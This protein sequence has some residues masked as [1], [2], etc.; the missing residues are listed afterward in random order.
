[1][2]LEQ[3]GVNSYTVELARNIDGQV[4]T[5]YAI[6]VVTPVFEHRKNMR[7]EM[8]AGRYR[9]MFDLHAFS[10]LELEFDKDLLTPF[11]R[12]M[13]GYASEKE[14]KR[15]LIELGLS[16]ELRAEAFALLQ[17]NG[18]IK[19]ST[20]PLHLEEYIT[21]DGL[22]KVTLEVSTYK[23]LRVFCEE[24]D[25]DG[26]KWRFEYERKFAFSP[27]ELR[28]STIVTRGK[29]CLRKLMCS[30]MDLEPELQFVGM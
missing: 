28:G 2:A 17:D 9:V 6:L 16:S 18:L 15:T 30:I 8:L 3:L 19:A 1:M 27:E 12:M 4:F 5:Q 23:S 21:K 25:V 13:A 24:R 14:V 29:E 20:K 10:A 26:E 22:Y 11:K 7:R